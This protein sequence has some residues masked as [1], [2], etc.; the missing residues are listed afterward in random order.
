[1]VFIILLFQPLLEPHYHH[2]ASSHLIISKLMHHFFIYSI[3]LHIRSL[4]CEMLNVYYPFLESLALAS[5]C[6][7]FKLV[8]KMATILALVTANTLFWLSLLCTDNQHLFYSIM[9]LFLFWHLMKRQI[10]LGYLPPQ[11]HIKSHSNVNLCPIFYLKTYLCHIEPFWKKSDR[12]HA[13]S[14]SGD[15][16]RQHMP[17][18]A[19]MISSQVRKVSGV[20]K[21][22]VS[23]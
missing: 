22:H 20:A 16:S 10:G 19:K 14:L 23:Q 11:I 3:P 21:A 2:K 5:S 17:V 12:S 1:M 9:L 13:Y 18:S 6:S 15:N 7:S 4:I 8:C